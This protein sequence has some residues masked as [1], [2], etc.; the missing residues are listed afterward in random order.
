MKIAKP[1]TPHALACSVSKVFFI[2]SI[3]RTKEQKTRLQC[4]ATAMSQFAM[5]AGDE[6][7]NVSKEAKSKYPATETFFFQ[8]YFQAALTRAPDM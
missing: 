2:Q 6:K 7:R 8:Q 1:F 4:L 5:P 3:C